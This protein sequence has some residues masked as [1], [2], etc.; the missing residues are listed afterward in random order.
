MHGFRVQGDIPPQPGRQKSVIA[1]DINPLVRPW[2]IQVLIWIRNKHE[3]HE[4]DQE[5]ENN[6]TDAGT[7]FVEQIG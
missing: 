6:G 4:P 2:D 5:A 7:T 1:V 3:S